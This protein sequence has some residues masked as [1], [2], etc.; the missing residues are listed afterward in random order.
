MRVPNDLILAK[1]VPEIDLIL[2][3]HDHIVMH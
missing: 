2:G 3:G 1:E